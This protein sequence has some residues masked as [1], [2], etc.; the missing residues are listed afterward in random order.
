MFVRNGLGRSPAGGDTES[1]AVIPG[2]GEP[3]LGKDAPSRRG[4]CA[5]AGEGPE[6]PGGRY[7]RGVTEM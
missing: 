4:R 2:E 7:R 6:A 3:D 5:A 1:R